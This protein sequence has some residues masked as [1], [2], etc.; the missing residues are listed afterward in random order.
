MPPDHVS[1]EDM[2]LWRRPETVRYAY[3]DGPHGLLHYRL[4]R[5]AASDHLPMLVFHQSGSSGRCYERLAADLG[6]DRVVAVMDSPGFGASDPVAHPALIPDF[7]T[8]AIALADHLGLQHVDLFGDHTGAATAIEMALQ[9]PQ[10][11]RRVVLNAAPLFTAEELTR[12]R[13]RDREVEACD[14]EGRHITMRWEWRRRNM[15]AAPVVLREMELVEAL[16]SG[17]FAGH[18]HHAAFAYDW[19]ANLSRMIHPLLVLRARDDLWEQTGR[20][21]PLLKNGHMVDLPDMGRE[22]IMVHHARIAALMREFLDPE[23]IAT[24]A[25]PGG[26]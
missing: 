23:C 25:S 18:G 11:V 5:P 19:A 26:T 24:D 7:V 3:A 20:A 4:V 10:R 12:L 22:M 13:S 16:R 1:R 21:K 14:A 8:A 6:R 2:E 9:Q 15:A 17:P